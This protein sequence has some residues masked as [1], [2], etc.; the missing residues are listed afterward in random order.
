MN[1]RTCTRCLQHASHESTPLPDNPFVHNAAIETCGFCGY[2]S[3]GILHLDSLSVY[4]EEQPPPN[5]EGDVIMTATALSMNGTPLHLEEPVTVVMHQQ[6]C[7]TVYG[8]P[9][10]IFGVAPTPDAGPTE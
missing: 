10:N 2:T 6:G 4:T 1:K 5:E 8:L 3:T 9:D 7:I